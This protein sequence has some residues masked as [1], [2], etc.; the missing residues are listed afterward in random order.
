MRSA[1]S[2][3]YVARK[4]QSEYASPAGDWDDHEASFN[5]PQERFQANVELD[6]PL[7]GE[8][9]QFQKSDISDCQCLAVTAGIVDC[10]PCFVREASWV[11]SEPDNHMR[12]DENPLEI[13]PIFNCRRNYVAHDLAFTFEKAI[14]VV[15]LLVGGNQFRYRFAP[16]GDH[17]RLSLGLNLCP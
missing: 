5:F 16:L 14:N 12:I 4:T 7:S 9:R 1:G 8:G 13:A 17:H 15:R 2:L 6:A 3:G 11:K 10:N